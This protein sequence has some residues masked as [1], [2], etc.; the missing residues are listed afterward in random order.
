MD[1][2]LLALTLAAAMV[3]LPALAAA[4]PP[5]C[6]QEPVVEVTHCRPPYFGPDEV[7]VCWYTQDF[8]CMQ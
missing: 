3:V 7:R 6:D 8:L 5:P 2:R 1:I 4:T